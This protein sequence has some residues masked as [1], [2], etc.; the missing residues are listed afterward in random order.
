M[1]P[2]N[3]SKVPQKN[4][5]EQAFDE[6]AVQF[7]QARRQIGNSTWHTKEFLGD[8]QEWKDRRSFFFFEVDAEFNR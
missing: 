2:C 3:W 1:F 4:V 6:N 5:A 8:A 7:N